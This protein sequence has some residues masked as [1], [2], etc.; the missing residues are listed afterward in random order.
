MYKNGSFSGRHIQINTNLKL[1][2]RCSIPLL[3]TLKIVCFFLHIVVSHQTRLSVESPVSDLWWGWFPSSCRFSWCWWGPPVSPCPWPP[4]WSTTRALCQGSWW[5]W[6]GGPFLW[7]TEVWRGWQALWGT[8]TFPPGCYYW[9]RKALWFSATL[10]YR[11]KFKSWIIIY[12]MGSVSKRNYASV[13]KF[14][15]KCNS[16]HSYLKK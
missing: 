12:C 16:L 2:R 4:L 13:L 10:S 7:G 14:P 6:L 15:L 3:Q 1:L 5:V 9:R 8:G 11:Q